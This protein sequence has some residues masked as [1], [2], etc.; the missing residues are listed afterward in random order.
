MSRKNTGARSAIHALCEMEQMEES[1]LY[2]KARMLLGIYRSACWSTIGRAEMISEEVCCYC[3][4]ELDDALIYLEVFAPEKEKERFECRI[5]S[6]FETRWMME[7][8]EMAMAKVYEF[9]G[10]GPV[11]HEIL[12]KCYLSKFHYSEAELLEILNL[13]RSRYYDRKKEAILVFGL[14]FWRGSLPRFKAFLEENERED[15]SYV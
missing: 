7:L 11:Y 12:S 6:L 3:G 2:A 13:E 15:M 14:S 8:V 10:N 4:P 1:Q 9:P 5:R